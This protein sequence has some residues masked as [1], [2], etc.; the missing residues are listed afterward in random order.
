MPILPLLFDLARNVAN[1]SRVGG[2]KVC[3]V[4]SMD[5]RALQSSLVGF[6]NY[7]ADQRLST[8]EERQ[9]QRPGTRHIGRQGQRLDMDAWLKSTV[10]LL[11]L[12]QTEA[13]AKR[14][15]RLGIVSRYLE[16]PG[17][18]HDPEGVGEEQVKAWRKRNL[19]RKLVFNTAFAL[20]VTALAVPADLDRLPLSDQLAYMRGLGSRAK[21]LF[22]PLT[23]HLFPAEAL[24]L[25]FDFS[26][27]TDAELKSFMAAL[28]RYRQES[29]EDRLSG[30][31]ANIAPAL[32]EIRDLLP[33]QSSTTEAPVAL[34]TLLA[35]VRGGSPVWFLRSRP[36]SLLR[37]I[38]PVAGATE[39]TQAAAS[40]DD[41]FDPRTDQ[42]GGTSW[43]SV[44]LL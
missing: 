33:D 17:R 8:F 9:K 37:L 19:V 22:E 13:I 39:Q 26:L 5:G 25:L 18:W 27:H 31:A 38:L 2:P 11:K 43:I 35:A 24:W 32:K 7:L 28:K 41:H 14:K 10:I 15:I 12:A 40:L 44:H 20:R 3:V 36:T 16:R 34:D 1:L 42:T 21:A 29:L 4:P 30:L 6:L 23:D